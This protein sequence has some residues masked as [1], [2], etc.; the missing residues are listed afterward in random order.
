MTLLEKR[1]L[2]KDENRDRME[3]TFKPF[4]KRW[5]KYSVD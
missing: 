4:G 1:V 2:P 3:F 5:G